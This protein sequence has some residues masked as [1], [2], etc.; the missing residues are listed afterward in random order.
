MEN[1]RVLLVVVPGAT[2]DAYCAELATTPAEWDVVDAVDQLET[3]LVDTPYNGLIL[4]VSTMIRATALQK[5]K[6]QTLLEFYPVLRLSHHPEGGPSRGLTDG[7]TPSR[8]STIEDF[9]RQDCA[10]F[11]ARPL[12][13]CQ[14]SSLTL[15]VLL[16]PQPDGARAEGQKA[17][18]VNVSESGCFIALPEPPACGAPLYAI[19]TDLEDRTPVPLEV[20]WRFAWGEAPRVPGFGARFLTLTPLQRDEIAAR[21]NTTHRFIAD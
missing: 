9:I 2:R 8:A 7:L 4:D 20:R 6:A 13:S 10:T 19:F 16:L 1:L 11:A 12:R 21:L 17:Y 3:T 5:R 15:N 14:R 18:T